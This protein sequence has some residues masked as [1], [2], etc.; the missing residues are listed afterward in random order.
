MSVKQLICTSILPLRKTDTV[1]TA[2][3]W[4]DEFRVSQLPLTDGEE[5]LGLVSDAEILDIED[6]ATKMSVFSNMPDKPFIME[7]EHY[8]NAMQML[9]E[10]NLSVLPVL[11]EKHLYLG[12]IT[13]EKI[14]NEIAGSL[15]V[16]NP[17]GI[18][19]LELNQNDYSLSEISRIVESNDAKILS[20]FINTASTSGKLE[21]TLKVNRINIEAIIQTFGRFNYDIVAYF[22]EN[23]KDD[24]LLLERY[25][26]LLTYLKY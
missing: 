16:Q 1:G 13:R 20:L 11:D 6:Q 17:G 14:L 3:E 21:I 18:I 4:M 2:L 10:Q 26:S 24:D 22:G 9:F 15:S 19:V 23:K 25:E 12:V 5:Y 8:Y 7:G